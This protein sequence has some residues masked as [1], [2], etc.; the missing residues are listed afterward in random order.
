MNL[1]SRMQQGY[2]KHVICQTCMQHWQCLS[3]QHRERLCAAELSGSSSLIYRFFFSNTI[4]RQQRIATTAVVRCSCRTHENCMHA[5]QI[6]IV[7]Y[8]FCFFALCIWYFFNCIIQTIVTVYTN[9]IFIYNY[10][11][12]MHQINL[13]P[14]GVL[15]QPEVKTCKKIARLAGL[16]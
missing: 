10:L 1:L 3:C 9:N 6:M 15:P 7:F 5:E 16:K 14:W 2:C 12:Q 8:T 4:T 11:W 13:H